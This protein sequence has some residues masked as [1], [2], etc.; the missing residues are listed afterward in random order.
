MPG[1]SDSNTVYALMIKDVMP[2]GVAGLVLGGVFA[3]SMSTADSYL[4]AG[5]S[6]F[7]NDI[8]RP[9]SGGLKSDRQVLKMSRFMTSAICFGSL[10]IATYIDSLI[11]IVY[12]G[13]LFYSTSV[14]F[15]MILGVFWK[16]ANA[17]GA[18]AGILASLVVGLSAEFLLTDMT[19]GLLSLPSNILSALSGLVVM[20]L[21]SLMTKAP[22][23]EK[24]EFI[25]YGKAS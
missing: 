20:I 17:V 6:L 10:I 16:R 25:D 13:G 3:A 4:M 11:D 18:F 14:F 15:P 24:I 7:I 21:I 23:K 19:S 12:L 5:T 2:P 9:I 1:I 8:Y 22:E